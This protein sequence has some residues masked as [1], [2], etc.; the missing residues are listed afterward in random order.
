M[1]EVQSIEE[2]IQR[3]SMFNNLNFD[4][5]KFYKNKLKNIRKWVGFSD[6]SGFIFAPHRWVAFPDMTRKNYSSSEYKNDRAK[7]ILT[8]HLGYPFSEESENNIVDFQEAKEKFLTFCPQDIK[9]S[10]SRKGDEGKPVEFWLVSPKYITIPEEDE[11]S[12]LHVEVATKQVLVNAY[13][14]NAKARAACIEYHK[15]SCKACGFN[16][17]KIYG[18]RGVDYIQVHHVK[19]LSEI[20]EAY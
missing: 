2:I 19:P 8:K 20:G 11:L 5:S 13:E 15:Y 18:K 7:R 17:E 14:R 10:F 3:I 16:F 12:N 9:P 4:D 6:D 1:K